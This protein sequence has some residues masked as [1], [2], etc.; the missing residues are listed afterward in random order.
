MSEGLEQLFISEIRRR[1]TGECQE[2]IL[3]CLDLLSEE[4]IWYRPNASS[5]SVGNLVLHL[6]GNVTQWLFSTMGNEMDHRVRQAEFDERG[7]ISSSELKVRVVEL[8]KKTDLILDKLDKGTL[9][10]TYSVQGFR[11]NG[12]A[13]LVHITEHFSYHVGQ[14]TYFVK[15]RKDLDVGYYAGQDLNQ[16]R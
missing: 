1:L 5:N 9:M 14:I 12:V 8:M 10:Q 13:I 6:C 3:R 16:T 11:E 7:P 2:R 15:A 4:D